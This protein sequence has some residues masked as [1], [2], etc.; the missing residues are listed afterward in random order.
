MNDVL[1]FTFLIVFIKNNLSNTV[2]NCKKWLKRMQ[3]RVIKTKKRVITHK[4]SIFSNIQTFS[5]SLYQP[6]LPNYQPI[7]Q[8]YRPFLGNYLLSTHHSPKSAIFHNYTKIKRS[9]KPVFNRSLASFFKSCPFSGLEPS[10]TL[11][12]STK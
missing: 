11:T 10:P 1:L 7:S 9:Q 5:L 8:N 2:D 6:F 4:Y 3:K 12:N